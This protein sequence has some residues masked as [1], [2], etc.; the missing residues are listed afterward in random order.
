MVT[1]QSGASAGRF[2]DIELA[3]KEHCQDYST[4]KTLSFLGARSTRRK[5]KEHYVVYLVFRGVLCAP[6]L[7]RPT[8]LN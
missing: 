8:P 5:H 3:V 2:Q 6:S 4:F 7:R 1:D